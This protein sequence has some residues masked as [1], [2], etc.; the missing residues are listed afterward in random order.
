[1]NNPYTHPSHTQLLEIFNITPIQANNCK[2]RIAL[3]KIKF[4]EERISIHYSHLNSLSPD[5]Q[6]FLLPWIN[7]MQTALE[8]HQATLHFLN[9]RNKE[10]RLK[11]KA[12]KEGTPIPKPKYITYDIDRIKEIPIKRIL[13]LFNIPYTRHNKFKLRN[14]KTPSCSIKEDGNIWKD[15][16]DQTGGSNIDLVMRLDGCN[17]QEALKFL[18]D[19]L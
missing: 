1:M 9:Q 12:I 6:D 2:R 11:A 8:K 16:G 17:F 14:E 4:L 7:G 3:N 5:S 15:F 13:T 10:E 18:N 19:Y